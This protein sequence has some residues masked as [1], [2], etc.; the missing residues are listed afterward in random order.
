MESI[1]QEFSNYKITVDGTVLSKRKGYR[2]YKNGPYIYQEHWVPLKPVLDKGNGYYLVTLC[3]T[4]T[5]GA[6]IRKNQFIHRLLAQAFIP[7][8]E[9]KAHVNH[10]DGNKT[11]NNL[12]NLEW[13][14]EKENSQHAVDI[15]LMT[16]TIFEKPVQ[17]Y[18]KDMKTLIGE[19]KSLAEAKRFTGVEAMNI[20]KVVRGI[21]SYAGGYHW[22]YKESVETNCQTAE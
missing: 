1:I 17:Q 15:G 2:N 8:P 19:F 9:N 21:R 16:H 10:I 22:K 20:S 3:K 6:K 7:N 12:S 11:N 13:T 14:T 5:D 18:A 4:G